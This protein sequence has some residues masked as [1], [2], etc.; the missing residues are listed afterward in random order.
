M[1]SRCRAP[2]GSRCMCPHSIF[3]IPKGVWARDWVH[4]C[5]L[6]HHRII[7][8]MLCV[9][10]HSESEWSW[11]WVAVRK[12]RLA[13]QASLTSARKWVCHYMYRVWPARLL[14]VQCKILESCSEFLLQWFD[15]WSPSSGITW[16][17][18]M[19]VITA[20]SKRCNKDCEQ[21]WACSACLN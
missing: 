11:K 20:S 18:C 12:L 5:R 15:M 17:A 1:L 10:W 19:K 7:K 16:L 2:S 4:A 3:P 13:S 14:D 9:H 6:Q 21:L 8:S